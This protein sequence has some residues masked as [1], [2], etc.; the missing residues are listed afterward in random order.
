[1]DCGTFS[2][3]QKD[4][5]RFNGCEHCQKEQPEQYEKLSTI[6]CPEHSLSLRYTDNKPHA[7]PYCGMGLMEAITAVPQPP[8]PPRP[9]ERTNK[10]ERFAHEVL[11]EIKSWDEQ[12]RNWLVGHLAPEIEQKARAEAFKAVKDL[13]PTESY[14]YY[15]SYGTSYE[16]GGGWKQ[17]FDINDI[18]E[19]Y[20]KEHIREHY[21]DEWHEFYESLLKLQKSLYPKSP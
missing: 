14:S 4:C 1:M 21:P 17:V 10:G 5:P 2:C 8:Q 9:E 18:P 16:D 6:K 19:D 12:K 3:L 15:V 11:E 7:C 13:V 20:P